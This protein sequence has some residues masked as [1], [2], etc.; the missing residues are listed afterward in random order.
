MANTKLSSAVIVSSNADPKPNNVVALPANGSDGTYTWACVGQKD[1][2][3]TSTITFSVSGTAASPIIVAG[4]T[5]Q[6][7]ATCNN[8]GGTNNFVKV[9]ATFVAPSNATNWTIIIGSTAS[10]T[11][12]FTRGTGGGAVRRGPQVK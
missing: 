4:T 5:N 11:A 1:V 9:T 6:V 8:R 12:R 10:N 3:S 2:G 7:Q